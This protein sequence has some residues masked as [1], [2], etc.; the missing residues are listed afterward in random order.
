MDK[1]ASLR[2]Y[3]EA[4]RADVVTLTFSQVEE[5]LGFLPESAWK[6]QAWW[7]NDKTHS[8]AQAWLA[9][10]WKTEAVSMTGER[11]TFRRESVG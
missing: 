7:A 10:G 4:E 3:L 1:Y 11:V 6:Y 9:A 2:R 8:E 5:I